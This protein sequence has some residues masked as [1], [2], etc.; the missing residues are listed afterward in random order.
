MTE[1]TFQ[2]VYN[3]GYNV[4]DKLRKEYFR[5]TGKGF[6][7]RDDPVFVQLVQQ[8]GEEANGP[9]CS[10]VIQEFPAAIPSSKPTSSH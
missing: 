4:S 9:Y 7:P 3:G 2:I 1:K 8:M 6:I 10:L 5:L